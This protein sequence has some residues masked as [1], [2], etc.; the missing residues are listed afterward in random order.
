M[1]WFPTSVEEV[2]PIIRGFRIVRLFQCS[3]QV[4]D[5]LST[6]SFYVKPWYTI[7]INLQKSIDDIWRDLKKK[8]CRYEIKRAE[9]INHHIVVN[10]WDLHTYRFIKRFSKRRNLPVISEQAFWELSKYGDMFV[11]VSNNSVIAAHVFVLD[12]PRRARLLISATADRNDARNRYLV[13]ALNRKLHWYEIQ[14]F[15]EKGYRWFDFGGI[16]L[17]PN[18]KL[19]SISRFKMSFGGIVVKEYDLWISSSKLIRTVGVLFAG[20]KKSIGMTW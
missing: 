9:K 6:V 15:K 8:S 11:V 1:V 2:A 7:L 12:Y 14:F 20:L 17:D 4:A 16:E 13:G 3:A 10:K 18:S 19:Y 5:G